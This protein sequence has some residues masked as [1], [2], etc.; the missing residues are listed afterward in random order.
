M[1]N[2]VLEP[3]WTLEDEVAVVAS[4]ALKANPTSLSLHASSPTESEEPEDDFVV[5]DMQPED[6]DPDHAYYIPSLTG[7]ISGCLSTILGQLASL[8][9][10]RPASMQNRIEPLNW[11]A[12]IDA[13]VSLE[14]PEYSNPK[15]VSVSRVHYFW[16]ECAAYQCVAK[17]HKTFRSHIWSASLRRRLIDKSS[18]SLSFHYGFNITNSVTVVIDRAE[19]FVASADRRDQQQATLLANVFDHGSPPGD[20]YPVESSSTRRGQIISAHDEEGTFR[21]FLVR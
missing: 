7:I 18:R 9:P 13:V 4:Q 19:Q 11:R 14:D 8:T 10:P 2:D 6:D 17:C 21:F 12:V 5:L 15:C 3:E 1:V 16:L 20:L